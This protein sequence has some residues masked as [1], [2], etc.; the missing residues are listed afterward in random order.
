[1]LSRSLLSLDMDYAISGIWDQTELLYDFKCCVYSTHKHTVKKPMLRLIIPFKRNV[2]E[3]EY[4]AVARMV[5]K[6]IGIDFFDG[7]T[8][9]P[10]R[11]MENY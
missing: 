5:A 3:D 2:S 10:A 6:E 1:M 9:E 4:P 8:Y 7:T 11:L